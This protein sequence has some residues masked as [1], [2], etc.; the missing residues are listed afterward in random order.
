MNTNHI[1][2]QEKNKILDNNI[3]CII[4]LRQLRGKIVTRGE[5]R[6]FIEDRNS[7]KPKA[8]D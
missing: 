8:I 7:D 3:R 2:E 6:R 1:S 4:K 5:L